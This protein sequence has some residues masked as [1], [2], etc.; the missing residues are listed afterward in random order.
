MQ[1]LIYQ[2]LVKETIGCT[3]HS[4]HP[5]DPSGVWQRAFAVAGQPLGTTCLTMFGAGQHVT[6][7]N[8][9]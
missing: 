8:S 1:K 4:V 7:L 9:V 2:K 5:A 6:S 3:W